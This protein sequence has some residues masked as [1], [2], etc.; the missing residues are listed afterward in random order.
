MISYKN[1]DFFKKQRLIKAKIDGETKFLVVRTHCQMAKYEV[2]PRK[3]PFVYYSRYL[4]DRMMYQEFDF[5]TYLVSQLRST[6]HYFVN[7]F[8]KDDI[9]Y[10]NI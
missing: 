7:D 5:G 4:W 1:S 6:A 3:L 8:N 9:I 2:K 10:L